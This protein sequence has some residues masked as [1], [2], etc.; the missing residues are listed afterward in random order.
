ML[1]VKNANLERKNYQRGT[2]FYHLIIK[3]GSGSTT[4]CNCFL[5]FLSLNVRKVEKSDKYAIWNEKNTNLERYYFKHYE[6][7][8]SISK[9]SDI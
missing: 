9:K 2:N 1:T 3:Y 6:V 7:K 8:I 4:L 5:I